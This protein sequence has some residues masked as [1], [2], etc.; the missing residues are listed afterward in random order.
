MLLQDLN[1]FLDAPS[2]NYENHR[3]ARSGRPWRCLSPG[4]LLS[5]QDNGDTGASWGAWS[6]VTTP[7]D[8]LTSSWAAAGVRDERL[9]DAVHQAF[10]LPDQVDSL[11]L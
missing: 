1:Y 5:G 6:V 8:V 10:E 3:T 2:P 11:L 9:D 7:D 4:K